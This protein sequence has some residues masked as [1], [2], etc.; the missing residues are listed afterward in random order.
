MIEF[1]LKLRTSQFS[2]ECFKSNLTKNTVE[3]SKQVLK[4]IL[5][6]IYLSSCRFVPTSLSGKSMETFVYLFVAWF[7][8]KAFPYVENGGLNLVI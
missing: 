4:Y 1:R 2:S 6:T 5:F 7:V 3:L 8:T